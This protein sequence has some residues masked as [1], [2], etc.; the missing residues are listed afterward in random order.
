MTRRIAVELIGGQAIARSLDVHRFEVRGGDPDVILA[1]TDEP[2]GEGRALQLR[3]FVRKGGGL[4]VVH[5]TLAAWSSL[6]PIQE[7]AGWIPTGPAP[8]TEL[9]LRPNP[10]HRVTQN[11]D[12]EWRVR[13]ELYLSEGPPLDADLLVRTSWRFT[14]QVVAYARQCGEGRFVYMGLSAYQDSSFQTLLARSLIFAAG[15]QPVEPAGVGL[16]GYGAIARDHA[17]AITAVGGL[18]LASICDLSVERRQ[19]AAREWS[20][21]THPRQQDLLEDPDVAVVV[22]GTP[23]SAHTEPV[24][25]ALEAGKHVVCEKPF[26]LRAEDA[27]RM[28]D[29]AVSRGLTLTVYQ[30]RRW[31]P[32][33]LAVRNAVRSGQIGDLFYME[34]FI[35]GFEHPCDYWHSHEPISGGTIYDWGSHYFDWILGLF[36]DRVTSVSAQAHKRVWHDVTN[37]DQVRVDLTFNGGQQASFLQ[38][39]V[40]AARK[41]KWYLLGTQGAIVGEWV[42]AAV[43][44]DFPANVK[45]FRPTGEERLALARRDDHGFYRNLAD[46]LAWGEPL[47]IPAQEARRNVAVME[48]ATQS[49]AR[50][51]E[52]LKVSI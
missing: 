36:D 5:G 50:G 47:A 29:S 52:L 16:L 22:V 17:A 41:P 31:D 30:S 19:L 7:M 35:G 44:A 32:D 38:S 13:D 37:A 11:L 48:A 33:Y 49:I 6:D 39:D 9:V 28:I 24:L 46:H 51:G 15:T 4:V 23:P 40:A 20:V 18:R 14:D 21:R 34:S 42:D 45:V 1:A 8:A 10:D 25:A 43:P 3:E 26:T 27:D 12:P 2:I